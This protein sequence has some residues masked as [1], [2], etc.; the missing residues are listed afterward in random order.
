MKLKPRIKDEL[1]KFLIHK[2]QAEKA[3]ARVISAQKLSEEEWTQVFQL[4]PDL[5]GKKIENEIDESLLA[6]IVVQKGSK[7]ID[8]SLKTQLNEF[9]KTAYAIY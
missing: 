1:R 9:R 8:L 7:I 2:Q 4:F 6:G 5:K 3:K